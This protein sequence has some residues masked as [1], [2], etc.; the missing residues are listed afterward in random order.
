MNRSG[1]YELAIRMPEESKGCFPRARNVS[2]VVRSGAGYTYQQVST[3]V[4]LPFGNFTLIAGASTFVTIDTSGVG[5]IYGE[6]GVKTCVAVVSVSMR[7]VAPIAVGCSASAPKHVR[8]LL[9]RTL[10]FRRTHLWLLVHGGLAE[11]ATTKATLGATQ[12]A[13]LLLLGP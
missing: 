1:V 10:A 12:V 11:L 6:R 5:A 7:R 9:R 13:A 8:L 2:V 4:S 3:N